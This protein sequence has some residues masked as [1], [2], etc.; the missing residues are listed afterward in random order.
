MDALDVA[1]LDAAGAADLRRASLDED[2]G[3]LAA[4]GLDVQAR[5]AWFPL[6]RRTAQRAQQAEAAEL[7]TPDAAR[8]AERSCAEPEVA[9]ALQPRA[10]QD[11]EQPELEAQPM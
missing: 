11:A 1:R 8:S 6:V 7:C 3:K 2:A 9:A 5:D 10:Q 4:L